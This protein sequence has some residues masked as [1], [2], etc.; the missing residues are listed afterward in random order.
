MIGLDTMDLPMNGSDIWTSKLKQEKN[1]IH[2]CVRRG[3]GPRRSSWKPVAVYSS[4]SN[5]GSQCARS[6]TSVGS[7]GPN[8]ALGCPGSE[9]RRPAASMPM[10]SRE[11]RGCV[12]VS[13]DT[14]HTYKRNETL[15]AFFT[16]HRQTIARGCQHRDFKDL[17]CMKSGHD[18]L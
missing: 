1:S 6:H 12:A 17:G 18:L 13:P 8:K 3:D 9:L 10:N 7:I 5:G 4:H 11:V 15:T 2:E 14:C 16:S